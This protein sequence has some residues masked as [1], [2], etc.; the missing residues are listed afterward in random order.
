MIFIGSMRSRV[1][2]VLPGYFNVE[3]RVAG[4]TV[5]IQPNAYSIRLRMRWLTA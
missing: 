4:V 5:L 2:G 3:C 1:I